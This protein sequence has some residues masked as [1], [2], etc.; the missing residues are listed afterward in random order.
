MSKN[1]FMQLINQHFP[2]IIVLEV[3]GEVSAKMLKGEG[4]SEEEAQSFYVEI[5]RRF[6]SYSDSIC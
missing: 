4:E 5:E 2:R 6:R 3:R 1:K